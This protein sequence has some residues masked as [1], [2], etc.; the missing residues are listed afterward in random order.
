MQVE[1]EDFFYISG[2]K[3]EQMAQNLIQKLKSASYLDR[4]RFPKG[5]ISKFEYISLIQD[6]LIRQEVQNIINNK[7]EFIPTKVEIQNS[8][9]FNPKSSDSIIFSYS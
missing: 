6:P 4:N 8:L 2:K 7:I 9:Q 5:Q 3:D 1:P